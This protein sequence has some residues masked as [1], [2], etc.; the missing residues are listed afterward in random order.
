M[1][2]TRRLGAAFLAVLSVLLLLLSG[3]GWWAKRYFLDSE[4]FADKANAILQQETVQDALAVAIT[5]Q[6]SQSAG[7]DLQIAQPF[8]ETI[9]SGV[10]RSSQFQTVFDGAVLRLH[11]AVVGG[12]ARD[13]V[14]DL[15]SMVDEIRNVIEPV[16]PNLAAEIPDGQQLRVTV[17]DKT[18]L[19]LV[20]DVTELVKDIVL[21]LTVAT[22]VVFALALWVSPRRWR[23]L[24]LTGWVMLGVFV[25]SL[26]AVRAGR[27]VTGSLAGQPEYSDAAQSAYKVITHGLVVQGVAFAVLGLLVGLGAGW[28]DRHGGW[29]VVRARLGRGADWAK[30]RVPPS[31]PAPAPAAAG[32]A[33]PAS[34][35]V[36]ERV[37]AVAPRTGARAVVAGVFAPRLPEPPHRTRAAHWW[38]A[39]GLLLVGLV[40][41]V[42]PGSL[43]TVIVVLLGVLAIYLAVTETVAA[44]TTPREPAEESGGAPSGP[45]APV[46][47]DA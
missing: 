23:T 6:L 29:A 24:A 46:T 28:T 30:S 32:T 26:V 5:D 39:A 12:G 44:S 16:A 19:G 45:G 17:L 37:G 14:L 43:T 3:Y 47:D 9:V 15:S 7:S 18:Q 33:G 21:G 20:Y 27:W 13:A 4:R 42:S 38:R 2:R 41:V 36:E 22:I 10:I 35:D 8:I 34:V 31:S 11:R 1:T 25:V 40:A